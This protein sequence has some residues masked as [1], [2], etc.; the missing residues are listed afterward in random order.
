MTKRESL[1]KVV[2]MWKIIAGFDK[3]TIKENFGE[4]FENALKAFAIAKM[5][6]EEEVINNC[7]ACEYAFEANLHEYCAECPLYDYK[8]REHSTCQSDGEPYLDWCL[9]IQRCDEKGASCAAERLAQLA[10]EKLAHLVQEKEVLKLQIEKGHGELDCLYFA[11]DNIYEVYDFATGCFSGCE[12]I[13]EYDVKKLYEENSRVDYETACL[14]I[15]VAET[16]PVYEDGVSNF[17]I[18]I[19]Q[20]FIELG[21]MMAKIKADVDLYKKFV[22]E[23]CKEK[24]TKISI[25]L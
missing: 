13:D 3:R 18:N 24:V 19:T 4:N 25:S 5:G 15:R 23:N 12:I 1:E 10:E 7:F 17:Y 21:G 6:V 20:P 16:Y 11:T 2:E 14:I 9:A 22:E 8:D